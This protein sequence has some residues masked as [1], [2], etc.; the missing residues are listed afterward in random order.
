LEP[1][2]LAPVPVVLGHLA[3]LVASALVAKLLA[4]RALE[5]AFATLATDGAVVT[6]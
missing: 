5:E 3:V 6:T 2:V 4:D 1:A